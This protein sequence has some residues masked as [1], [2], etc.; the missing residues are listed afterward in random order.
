MMQ[1]GPGGLGLLPEAQPKAQWTG[2][3]PP[4]TETM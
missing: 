1:R 4:T 2:E 3:P